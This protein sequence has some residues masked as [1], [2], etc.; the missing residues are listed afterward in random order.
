MA[1][2]LGVKEVRFDWHKALVEFQPTIVA[3]ATP[4]RPHR[5]ITVA[6]AEAGCHVV[7]EKPLAVHAGEAREMLAAVERAG[8][9]HAYAATGCY[10]APY[11]HAR[12]LLTEGRIGQVRDIEYLMHIGSL[13][14][15][16]PYSWFH[17]LN[18]GG[19][20]LNNL[21]THQ[22]QQ[23]LLMTGGAVTA[24]MGRTSSSIDRAPVGPAVHDFR[25]FFEAVLTPEQAAT[26]EW[27]A[28]DVDFGFTLLAQL[29]MPN[30]HIAT[31]LFAT[32]AEA[33]L[34]QPNYIALHG[35]QGTLYLASA[36]GGWW[37]DDNMQHFD[38][39][40]ATWN[41]IS[42]PRDVVDALPAVEDH[43]QR[44]WNQF[45][46]D[47]VADVRGEGYAGYPTFR[48]GWIAV[49]VTDIARSG[50]SWTPVDGTS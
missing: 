8:V 3:I 11:L 21:F 22:L 5:E 7:C 39:G 1:E 13:P 45:F 43:V 16:L 50:Q 48:D 9:K 31:A 15:T 24:V 37:P 34:P 28:V 18:E 2:K 35:T 25:Q 32:P 44:Q 4:A 26:A 46:R 33:S 47:F 29:R 23:V 49:E 17:Q 6:A 19:G 41:E 20:M 10:A 12:A 30:G 40:V 38:T 27:R 42:I 36:P 14:P